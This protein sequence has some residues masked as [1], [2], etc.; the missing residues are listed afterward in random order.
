MCRSEPQA[1]TP[2]ELPTGSQLTPRRSPPFTPGSGRSW[3]KSSCG[4]LVAWGLGAPPSCCAGA[5][6]P[7]GGYPAS[8]PSGAGGELGTSATAR[9]AGSCGGGGAHAVARGSGIPGSGSVRGSGMGSSSRTSGP[10]LRRR[11][12]GRPASSSCAMLSGMLPLPPPPS[13]STLPEGSSDARLCAA[14]GNDAGACGS[15]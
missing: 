2:R 10:S 5:L 15:C 12:A 4:R 8:S 13:M 6:A 3:S 14:E 7:A 11:C 1:G 9:E